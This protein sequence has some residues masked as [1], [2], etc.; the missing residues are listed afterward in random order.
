MVGET[1]MDP[2]SL[3]RE[4]YRI[5]G[6]TETECRSIFLDWALGLPLG[7]DSRTAIEAILDL[8]S[9]GNPDHPMGDV[10]RQGLE[11]MANPKRR[12]GWRAR[13]RPR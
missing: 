10:L 4:A 2:K 13:E 5:E 3:M 6:I 8:Y 1:E 9:A 12:G 11:N 7:Q